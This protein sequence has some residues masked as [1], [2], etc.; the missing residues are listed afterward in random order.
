MVCRI[1]EN[2]QRRDSNAANFIKALIFGQVTIT[3]GQLQFRFWSGRTSAQVNKTSHD[4]KP[5]CHKPCYAALYGPKGANNCLPNI[6]QLQAS[7]RFLVSRTSAQG[8]TKQC[9]SVSADIQTVKRACVSFFVFQL[10]RS[11]PWVKTGTDPVCAVRGAARLWLQAAMQSEH[12]FCFKLQHDGQPYCHKPC[13][14]VLFGPKGV[15]TGGVGSYI[16]EDPNSESQS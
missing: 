8:A 5:Y 14:A 2:R 13:Y 6:L 4:G 15:N 1:D 7:V 3:S 16:Y 11:V 9:T 12:G 10:K